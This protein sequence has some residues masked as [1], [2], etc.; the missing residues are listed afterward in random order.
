MK[1]KIVE[2]II[3]IFF[4]C[5]QVTLGSAIELGGIK[6]NMLIVLPILF[7]YLNGSNE[8]MFVGFFSGFIYDIFITTIIGFSPL[9]FSVLGYI[10][11]LFFQKYE[12]SEIIIPLVV[13]AFGDILYEFLS[14]V[15]NFLLHNRLNVLYFIERFMIP[16]MIYTVL[17]FILVF[18]PIVLMNPL[19]ESKEKRRVSYFDERDN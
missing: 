8:G 15:G 12:K 13:V 17:F 10:S 7:G 3:I 2:L 18:K 4:Y 14:Y 11:G 1:R 5:L 19:L 9:V 16:E 6:P